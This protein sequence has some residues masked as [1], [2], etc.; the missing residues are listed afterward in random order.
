LNLVLEEQVSVPT[1][2]Y[3]IV[4]TFFKLYDHQKLP[5]IIAS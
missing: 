5:S 3:N 4:S 1:E 2:T